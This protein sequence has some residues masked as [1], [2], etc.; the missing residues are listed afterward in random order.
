MAPSDA[1]KIQFAS[2]VLARNWEKMSGRHKDCDEC[3]FQRVFW[4]LIKMSSNPFLFWYTVSW[5]TRNVLCVIQFSLTNGLIWLMTVPASHR[6]CLRS[7]WWC[8]SMQTRWFTNIQKGWC[9]ILDLK[10]DRLSSLVFHWVSLFG[11]RFRFYCYPVC[12]GR[13]HQR[14][15]RR[16][17]SRNASRLYLDLLVAWSS[18]PRDLIVHGPFYL[19]SFDTSFTLFILQRFDSE[20]FCYWTYMISTIN[21]QC[22]PLFFP[23]LLLWHHESLAY[24][25]SNFKLQRLVFWDQV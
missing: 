23:M 6:G 21:S 13:L 17:V 11:A 7:E 3:N 24:M 8:K 5:F 1:A 25:F 14:P 9:S 18:S 12:W 20:A 15:V 2:F 4:V 22:L 19:W 10:S 16:W